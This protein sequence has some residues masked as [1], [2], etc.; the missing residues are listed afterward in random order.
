MHTDLKIL[1]YSNFVTP[2]HRFLP[3][4]PNCLENVL[5]K[6][7]FQSNVTPNVTPENSNNNFYKIT[8]SDYQKFDFLFQK[9]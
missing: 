4:S 1:S 7:N 9:N 8:I 5:K 2:L 3:E 6:S